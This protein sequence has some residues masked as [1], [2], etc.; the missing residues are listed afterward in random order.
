LLTSSKPIADRGSLAARVF[1]DRNLNGV[2]DAGD[3]LLP[4]ATLDID[5]RRDFNAQT[6]GDDVVRTGV[7]PY[8]RTNISVNEASL[9]DPYMKPID[10]TSFVPRSGHMERIDLAVVETAEAEGALQLADQNEPR[11]LA[12]IKIQLLDA[13]GK[14]VQEAASAY[15]GYFYFSKLVPGRYSVAI[16]QSAARA[17]AYDYVL[18]QAFDVAPGAIKTGLGITARRRADTP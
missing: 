9:T 16:D 5:H 1:L 4:N 17:A 10:G 13:S 8:R 7:E 11:P 6:I 3:Q 2:Y 15:D 18:P 14:V 12:G